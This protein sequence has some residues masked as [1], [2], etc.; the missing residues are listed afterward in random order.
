[1]IPTFALEPAF[2]PPPALQVSWA[3]DAI[4][5]GL[6]REAHRERYGH[7]LSWIEIRTG[8]ET[9]VLV[10]AGCGDRAPIGAEYGLSLIGV[11]CGA[12]I[13]NHAR[14]GRL[15]ALRRSS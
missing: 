6:S 4:S 15:R 3:F 13:D 9:R 11:M 1:M 5:R 14:C 12:F 2:S 10:C 8:G 7:D